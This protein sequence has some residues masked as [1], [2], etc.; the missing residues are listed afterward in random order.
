MTGRAKGLGLL[1][2]GVAAAALCASWGYREW[3]ESTLLDSAR[4]A[5]NRGAFA[6]AARDFR[7]VL[8]RRPGH[9]EAAFGLGVCEEAAGRPDA[10]LA[11][12]ERIGPASPYA[13]VAAARIAPIALERGQ[14]ARAE[15]LLRKAAST[16]GPQVADAREMLVRVLRFEDRRDEARDVLRQELR[17]APDTLKAVRALWMLEVEP[18]ALERTLALFRKAARDAPGDDRVWLGLANLARRAG[19]LDEA[20]RWLRECRKARPEDH[21]VWRSWLAWAR[22]A[23]DAAEARLALGHLPARGFSTGEVE[24]LRAWFARSAG[25]RPGERRALERLAACAPFVPGALERLAELHA[26]DGEP[27]KAG[28]LRR[29][30]AELD[31]ARER[32]DRLFDGGGDQLSAL[33]REM[34]GLAE[35]LGRGAEA[36]G[37]WM[38]ELGTHPGDD[39]ARAALA[40]LERSRARWEPGST[41]ADLLAVATPTPRTARPPARPGIPGTPARPAFDDDA[42]RV[43]LDFTFDHDRS[44][45]CRLPETMSGGIGLLDYDGDGWLDVYCVQGGPL[46][47]PA[48][49]RPRPRPGDRLFHNRGD[50][51]F[52]DATRSSGIAALPQGYGHGV[53]VGDHD[54]DGWPD[55]FVTRFGSYALYRNRGDGTFEDRTEAAGLGGRRGWPTSASFAD[56]DG[57]GDLDLYVC[58]YVRWD[59][60]HAERCHDRESKRPTY[61]EPKRFESE[62]DR[63]FRNDGGRFVDVSE[64]AGIVDREGRGLGVVAV[65]LDGDRLVDLFVANDT[66]AN[67]AF[68]NQGGLRFRE[69]G[70]ESGLAANAAS[71]FLAGM[72]V[73]CGDPD[74]DGLPDLAVTNF[75]DE[76]TT[77]YRNLGR[78]LF[79]DHSAAAGVAP[80]SRYLL[81]FGIAFLD[82]DNDGRLDLV[83]ANGHVNDYRDLYPYAMPVL[84]LAGDPSGRFVDVTRAAGPPLTTARLGRGL[85]V[86]DLDNDGKVDVLVVS[87]GA[88]LGYFHNETRGGHFLTLQLEGAEPSSRDAVGARV[89]VASGGVRQSAWRFGGGSYLSASDPRLHFGLGDRDRVDSIDV[90]WPSGRVSRFE[91][92]KA[93]AAYR[94]RE[95]RSAPEPLS[96]FGHARPDLRARRADR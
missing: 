63:L 28:E 73:A 31:A 89:V 1:V 47:A 90:Y 53:A 11:A 78:G 57:D 49:G 15:D 59:P 74:G 51:T 72:G 30:K 48:D 65:D 35:T 24:E 64:A 61:C 95:G 76:S 56:L 45:E 34:A 39:D 13:V 20:A 33:A 3:E 2:L 6:A 86:G 69:S 44:D 7:A 83:T 79:A 12:W 93:D 25:D 10:A 38:I 52:E 70:L 58:H 41:L 81:G 37:W 96:G 8:R 50:G 19:R 60:E 55:L 92:L 27:G 26:L 22:A 23:G 9:D 80:P 21:A 94:L 66:T 71:G 75:Y 88:P 42:G 54:G 67:F 84:L 29:R 43:G 46:L 91:S 40:R 68:L 16:R 82:F 18:V 85:A 32:Y 5:A 62:P 87:Q 14:F 17:T 4:D 36:E 77:L